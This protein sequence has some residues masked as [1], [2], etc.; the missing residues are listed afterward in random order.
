M[1]FHVLH[2]RLFADAASMPSVDC[3]SMTARIPD[4]PSLDGLEARWTARW[5][6]DGTYRFDRSK[7]RAEIFS[8]DTPPPTVSGK[9]HIG[10]AFGYIQTDTLVRYRRMAGAEVYSPMGWDDNGLNT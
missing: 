6:A 10:N 1:Q 8:V 3:S 7:P 2:L 9:L 4:K 5:D